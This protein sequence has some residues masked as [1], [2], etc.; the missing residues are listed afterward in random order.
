MTVIDWNFKCLTAY[1]SERTA[2]KIGE[3]VKKVRLSQETLVLT[4]S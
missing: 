3:W 4:L 1:G 2:P